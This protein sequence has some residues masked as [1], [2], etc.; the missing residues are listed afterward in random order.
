MV[1]FWATLASQAEWALVN[2]CPKKVGI[3]KKAKANIIGITPAVI[4]LS[5]K[6][7]STPP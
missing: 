7:V 6:W 4:T 1:S 2:N 3:D 5:G